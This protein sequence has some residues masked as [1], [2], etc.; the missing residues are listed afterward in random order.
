V[1]YA[2]FKSSQRETEYLIHK[3][4]LAMTGNVEGIA[5]A[6]PG[7]SLDDLRTPIATLVLHHERTLAYHPTHTM[8][9]S[10]DGPAGMLIVKQQPT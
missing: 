9:V 7:V 10:N 8:V 1:T 6:V 2:L 5:N 3:P 4:H